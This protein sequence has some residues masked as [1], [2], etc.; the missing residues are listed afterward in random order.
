MAI[1]IPVQEDLAMKISV[2]VINVPK[3]VFS[4]KDHEKTNAYIVMLY[5]VSMGVGVHIVTQQ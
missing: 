4:V 3:I 2:Y 5:M 1:A